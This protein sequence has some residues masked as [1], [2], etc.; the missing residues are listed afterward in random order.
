MNTKTKKSHKT[1]KSI[2]F[3][4]GVYL[5]HASTTYLIPEVER[6][7]LPYGQKIYGNPSSLHKAGREAKVAVDRARQT[8]A[9][10]LNCSVSEVIFTG[11]GTESDNMAIL[12][13]ARAFRTA[14]PSIKN[15][16]IITSKI[17]HHAVLDS[18]RQLEKEGFAATYL[19][20][21]KDG[22]VEPEAVK[23]AIR[24]ETALVSIMYANNEI[25]TIQ[26]IAEIAKAISEFRIK[27]S[28]LRKNKGENSKFL[29]HNSKLT[30][31]PLFHT[32]ACQA[33]G[34]LDIGVKK[35]GVDLMTVN[36]SKIYGPKGV[37]VL[38]KKSEVK[39]Q[40][41][42][43]GGGQEMG[44]RSGTENVANIVGMAKALELAEK[45]RKS[46]SR[47]LAGLRDYFIRELI[48]RIP[49]TRLNG[50][51]QKRL[52]NNV[53]VSILDVEGEAVI[54]HLDELGIYASTGS[55]CASGSL[56]PSHVILALGLGYEYAHGSLRF[57]LGKRNTKRDV[58]YVL[59]VLPGIVEKLRLMSPVRVK[60]R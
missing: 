54:L 1:R 52:P 12:G 30:A 53:N 48:R 32:D 49:K 7:M 26:P 50:H 21:G 15:P 42:V 59:K 4:V 3:G 16:H 6:A 47:R 11:S 44:L 14:H 34:A 60:M 2:R 40:P 27:N 23:K 24:P 25:G 41:L 45:K 20:V 39:I 17:E 51:P 9:K 22:L 37:G 57:T 55:A 43:F 38:Y 5:D 29:I 36:G 35:L 8:V 19:P 28:E 33:P 46:E 10:I 18:C 56:E 31:Y 13:A 58:D